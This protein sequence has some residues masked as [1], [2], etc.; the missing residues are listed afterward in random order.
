[1]AAG[2]E[3]D[4]DTALATLFEGKLGPAIASDA[5]RYAPK[6]TGALAESVEHHM[7]G[8]A[9]IVS[10]TGGAGGREYAADVELGH[11]VYHPSTGITGPE[12]V[13]PE[14]FLRPALYQER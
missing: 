5:A 8:R 10:A 6:D 9:L 11:R 12:V 13:P 7:E 2:W 4:V 3:A 1:M 14:P